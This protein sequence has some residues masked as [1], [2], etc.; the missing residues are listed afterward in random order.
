MATTPVSDKNPDFNP[1]KPFVWERTI[2]LDSSN[3]QGWL[4]QS[5]DLGY[6]VDKIPCVRFDEAKRLVSEKYDRPIKNP[7][8]LEPEEEVLIGKSVSY[9]HLG[10][11]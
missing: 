7:Y 2:T 11:E 1:A 6:R 3:Y 5:G 8:D 9:T 10:A 4:L